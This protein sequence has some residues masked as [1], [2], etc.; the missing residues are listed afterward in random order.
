MQDEEFHVR[1][2]QVYCKGDFETWDPKITTPP[3][4]YLISWAIYRLRGRCSIIDLR[5]LNVVTV[6]LGYVLTY[7][8]LRW[9][10]RSQTSPSNG[11]LLALTAANTWLFPP[12]FFFSGLYYT[13]VQSAI[14]VLLSYRSYLQYEASIFSWR[15]G[16]LQ[17]L[18]GIIALFF[19]QTN[20][21][22][23]AIFPAGL[24]LITSAAQQSS[25]T[26]GAF[27]GV[28]KSDPITVVTDSWKKMRFYDL[29]V[30]DAGMEG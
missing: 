22:W 9:Q 12:L 16:L 26:P 3:G 27:G 4:L 20:I 11:L 29:P 5:A 23:V 21:F 13:D 2:A 6:I 10:R 8:I 18:V 14:W 19:R 1:Q 24:S 7:D 17:V 15:N 28:R 30:Y 25:R